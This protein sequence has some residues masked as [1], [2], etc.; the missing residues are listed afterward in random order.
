[1]IPARYLLTMPKHPKRPRD[2][3]ELA[4]L[5]GEIAT[6]QAADDAAPS[7]NSLRAAKGGEAR[8]KSLSRSRRVA[9]AR[10]GGKAAQKRRRS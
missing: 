4:K 6:G 2:M 1:V 8:A 7:P 10:K 9:I 3:M 5:V